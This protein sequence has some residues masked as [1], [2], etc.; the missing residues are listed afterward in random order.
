MLTGRRPAAAAR[1][2]VSVRR[3][4]TRCGRC[5]ATPRWRRTGGAGARGASGS[6]D[7]RLEIPSSSGT[8]LGR[9]RR[10]RCSSGCEEKLGV[11]SRGADASAAGGCRLGHGCAGTRVATHA[12]GGPCSWGGAGTAENS[13]TPDETFGLTSQFANREAQ[14]RVGVA[15]AF[16]SYAA[17]SLLRWD[18]SC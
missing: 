17:E 11:L 10:T 7:L 1:R 9:S 13:D 3:P 5:A 4:T 6:A 16:V 8:N 18:L 12:R 15:D 14:L 2:P